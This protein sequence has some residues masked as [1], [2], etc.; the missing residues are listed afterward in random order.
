MAQVATV[1]QNGSLTSEFPHAKDVAIKKKKEEEQKITV[2]G[3]A[4]KK[5][6]PLCS[7]ARIVKWYI[8]YGKLYEF[9][10]KK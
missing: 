8:C 9:S 6:E 4:V 1:P 3:E 7:V 5:L 10:S 2:V